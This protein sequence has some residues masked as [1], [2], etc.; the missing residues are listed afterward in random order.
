MSACLPSGA[1]SHRIC[2]LPSR[3]GVEGFFLPGAP[4][5]ER[6]RRPL[7]RG[8]P[9]RR[10]PHRARDHRAQPR[11]LADRRAC[12]H[13]HARR[14]DRAPARRRHR[15]VRGR[16]VPVGALDIGLYR[17]DLPSMELR[18]RIQRTEM[19]VGHRRLA[20]RAR[21][22]RALHRPQHPRRAGRPDR[23]RAAGQHPARRARRPRPPRA[24]HPRRLRR[25]EH[26]DRPA[27]GRPGACFEET[28]GVDEVRLSR[29][30]GER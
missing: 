15:G 22:R 6:P 5:A 2:E 28:D 3:S 19:P 7:R 14:A 16:A 13:A 20:R 18:P 23:L 26:P 1:Q 27:R 29:T 12:R 11:A 4:P 24:A 8:H 30:E 10:P 21:G 25:Q 9:P 17:D